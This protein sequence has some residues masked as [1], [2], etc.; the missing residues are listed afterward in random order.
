MLG[1]LVIYHGI[2]DLFWTWITVKKI[3]VNPAILF[4]I[5]NVL[6]HS[7]CVFQQTFSI[8][9]GQVIYFSDRSSQRIWFFGFG[10]LSVLCLSLKGHQNSLW[11]LI[12]KENG[13]TIFRNFWKNSCRKRREHWY[14][15][16]ISRVLMVIP[17]YR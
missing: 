16:R 5:T 9:W 15:S 14:F 11:I 3:M 17:E 8:C 10:W 2:L 4:S 13:I 12:G 7:F 1:T 6:G